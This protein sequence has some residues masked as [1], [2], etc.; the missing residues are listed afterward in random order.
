V[1]VTRCCGALAGLDVF[2]G[3]TQGVALGWY[4]A[5]LQPAGC[6]L[7]LAIW[8]GLGRVAQG[9]ARYSLLPGPVHG[10]LAA[11]GIGEHFG[12]YVGVAPGWYEGRRWRPR[13]KVK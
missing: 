4:M 5:C 13:W 3:I 12:E 9:S 1:G 2:G 10:G 6:S 11:C 7:G 8:R